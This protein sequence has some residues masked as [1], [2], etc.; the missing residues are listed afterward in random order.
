MRKI[1]IFLKKIITLL[2]GYKNYFFLREI[3]DNKKFCSKDFLKKR[4]IIIGSTNF[5]DYITRYKKSEFYHIKKFGIKAIIYC[6]FVNSHEAIIDKTNFFSSK[7][8]ISKN[9][10]FK[11][12]LKLYDKKITLFYEK[13]D[14]PAF[15]EKIVNIKFLEF[16]DVID[17][18]INNPH[19]LIDNN[20]K[21]LFFKRRDYLTR[22]MIYNNDLNKEL[23]QENKNKFSK[24]LLFIVYDQKNYIKKY[25]IFQYFKNYANLKKNNIDYT[26]INP[27]K[28]NYSENFL[29][30]IL[31]LYFL[32][33]K[34]ILT[35][36]NKIQNK[37]L[38]HIVKKFYKKPLFV[39]DIK[40]PIK[41]SINKTDIDN[42]K[43]I[44]ENIYKFKTQLNEIVFKK[45]KTF[46]SF[47]K[48]KIV[49]F[50]T[51]NRIKYLSNI[52][53]NLNRIDI[54]VFK[55]YFLCH[56]I[57]DYKTKI[58]TYFKNLKFRK[59]YIFDN[60]PGH[61]KLINM[62]LKNLDKDIIWLKLDDDDNYYRG[63]FEEVLSN[64][65]IS[66]CCYVGKKIGY[67][68][69]K[70]K[71]NFITISENI[72]RRSRMNVDHVSG[73]S[74]AGISN[75]KKKL[76]IPEIKTNKLDTSISR[77]CRVSKIDYFIGSGLFVQVNRFNN[78]YHTW[79]I[80][81]RHKN[82]GITKKILDEFY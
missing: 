2:L 60:N 54:K 8:K 6:L 43:E 65:R 50:V 73:A 25:D 48:K 53:K 7:I 9:F 13:K 38:R 20:F 35:N 79:K 41:K 51:L 5:F 33:K 47:K 15:I 69:F 59:V 81:N 23:T 62:A 78:K 66:N 26:L 76:T 17:F 82:L 64:I 14:N 56:K 67:Y 77:I 40:L 4:M 12:F 21:D 39:D 74:M 29:N 16:D 70:K 46:D 3:I 42:Y 36:K 27:N 63:Y 34:I 57:S 75:I 52:K 19:K 61:G 11:I 32:G 22:I 55:V 80:K 45:N 37:K 58:K 28:K 30:K 49:I 10:F 31:I 72:F 71:S 18:T 1:K 24:N 44:F 68:K